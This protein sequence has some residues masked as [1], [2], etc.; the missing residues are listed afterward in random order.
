[1]MYVAVSRLRD[2]SRAKKECPCIYYSYQFNIS[3]QADPN[4]LFKIYRHYYI[5]T[6]VIFFIIGITEIK[7]SFIKLLHL[8]VSNF[9]ITNSRLNRF[10]KS[11]YKVHKHIH[12]EPS[13]KMLRKPA[14]LRRN[15]QRVLQVV[16][17]RRQ[18][19]HLLLAINAVTCGCSQC[20]MFTTAILT[21]VAIFSTKM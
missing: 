19:R 4:I 18:R 2:V 13:E 7:P 20:Q 17:E 9:I 15:S 3:K 8:F 16:Y 5:N 12:H 1:M 11:Y 14:F 6:F 10:F 21:S